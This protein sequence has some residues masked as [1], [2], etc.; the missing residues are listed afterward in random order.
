MCGF[1]GF[2][3]EA[4]SVVHRCV[5]TQSWMSIRFIAT[6]CAGQHLLA[7]PATLFRNLL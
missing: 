5:V 7:P 2:E 4:E 1:A 6:P 3:K